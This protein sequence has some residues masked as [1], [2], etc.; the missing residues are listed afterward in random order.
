MSKNKHELCGQIIKDV[1]ENRHYY[2]FEG[3]GLIEDLLSKFGIGTISF[4]GSLKVVHDKHMELLKDYI[5]NDAT[6]DDLKAIYKVL[7]KYEKEVL[8][9]D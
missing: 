1:E 7:K 6:D 4:K 8:K 9:H 3:W 2:Y 5:L